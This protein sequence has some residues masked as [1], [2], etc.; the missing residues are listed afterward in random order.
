MA[1]LAALD[2]ALAER[3]AFWTLDSSQARAKLPTAICD[4]VI[5]PEDSL[6]FKQAFIQGLVE[7]LGAMLAAFPDNLLWDIEALAARQRAQALLDSDPAGRLRSLWRRVADLQHL[8]GVKGPIRFRYIHDF[9]YGFDWAKW[10]AKDPDGRASVGPY[11][12]AF[13]E[14]MHRRGGELLTLIDAG[15]AKYGPLP[16]EGARNPFGFSREPE[17]ELALHRR[18]A[19]EG[20]LPV[21]AWTRD[22]VPDWRR[23]YAQLREEAAEALRISA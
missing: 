8:F 1:D 13:I 20:S 6:A 11:D 22:A 19:A 23:P 5:Q 15:D 10:V 3:T 21:H 9:V 12:A 17:D 18:L 16:D 14:R 2:V 4:R 7:A